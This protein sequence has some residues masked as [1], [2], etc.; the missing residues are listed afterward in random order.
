MGRATYDVLAALHDIPLFH[1]KVE[2]S[3]CARR[4][5]EQKKPG[6][7][8]L[9]ALC[10]NDPQVLGRRWDA[11]GAGAVVWQEAGLTCGRYD[12]TRPKQMKV[13]R[14]VVNLS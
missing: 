11:L 3:R 4:T 12:T 14:A 2:H 10:Q 6:T 8:T 13:E 5:S 7:E 1:E 9:R